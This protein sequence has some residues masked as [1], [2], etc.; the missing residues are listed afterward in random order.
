MKGSFRMR[1][2]EGYQRLDDGVERS[3]TEEVGIAKPLDRFLNICDRAERDFGVEG[4]DHSWDESSQVSTDPSGLRGLTLT[5]SDAAD[6]R[7]II[8]TL[9]RHTWAMILYK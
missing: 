9:K 6:V 4:V 7:L 5:L 1:T 8:E 2:K 3:F